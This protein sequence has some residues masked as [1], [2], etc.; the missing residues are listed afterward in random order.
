[1]MVCLGSIIRV[2]SVV[3]MF[4][5]GCGKDMETYICTS[6]QEPAPV[7]QFTDNIEVKPHIGEADR[8]L[9]VVYIHGTVVPALTPSVLFRASKKAYKENISYKD[10]VDHAIRYHSFCVEQPCGPLGLQA[11]DDPMDVPPHAQRKRQK[12][13]EVTKQVWAKTFQGIYKS[14]EPYSFG[15]DG[16]LSHKNRVK[17]AALLYDQLLEKLKFMSKKHK[18]PSPNIDIVVVGHSHGGNIG[19]LLADHKH[20]GSLEVKTLVT[21]GMPVQSETSYLAHDPI[22]RRVV[23]IFSKGDLVQVIDFVSTQDDSSSR[24]LIF[25]ENNKRITQFQIDCEGIRPNHSELWFWSGKRTLFYRD[26]LSLSPWPVAAFTPYILWHVWN[27]NLL[28]DHHIT[29][30]RCRDKYHLRFSIARD[31]QTPHDV[32]HIDH[33]QMVVENHEELFNS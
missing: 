4:L 29:F 21:L 6:C 12:F 9:L 14:V 33:K 7:R 23:N 15:W 5:A 24:R 30:E 13:S 2:L 31:K 17:A 18:V 22:F 3:I 11:F 28:G 16:K 10:A 27:K 19:L 1:M 8:V 20:K 26:Y 25:D 32:F